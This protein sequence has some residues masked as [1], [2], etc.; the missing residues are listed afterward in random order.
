LKVPP[1]PNFAR[2]R[3]ALPDLSQVFRAH[4]RSAHGWSSQTFPGDR[5]LAPEKRCALDRLYQRIVDDLDAL[6]P[7]VGLK[8]AA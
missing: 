2:L 6:L 8:V 4:L 1:L 7:A 3:F 5:K